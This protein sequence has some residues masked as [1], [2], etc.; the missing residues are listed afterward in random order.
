[1]MIIRARDIENSKWKRNTKNNQKSNKGR[2]EP[3]GDRSYSEQVRAKWET[4]EMLQRVL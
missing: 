2:K 3:G 4:L 1:M